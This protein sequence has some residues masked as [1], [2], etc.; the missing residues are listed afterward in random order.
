MHDCNFFV[1]VLF[2]PSRVDTPSKR[3]NVKGT[4]YSLISWW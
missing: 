4:A 3:V 2:S 1:P